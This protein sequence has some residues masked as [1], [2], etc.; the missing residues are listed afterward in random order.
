MNEWARPFLV[1]KHKRKMIG[2]WKW[3]NGIFSFWISRDLDFMGK[4]IKQPSLKSPAS[5]K[6]ESHPVGR[7]SV[8]LPGILFTSATLG[9]TTDVSSASNSE[10]KKGLRHCRSWVKSCGNSYQTTIN[11]DDKRSSQKSCFVTS[12]CRKTQTEATHKQLGAKK[13][14]GGWAT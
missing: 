13:S 10:N 3:W 4:E 11:E 7:V 2:R 8:P 5:Q 6:F 12:A 1:I 14:S 9:L